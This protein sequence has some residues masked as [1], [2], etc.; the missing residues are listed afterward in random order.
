MKSKPSKQNEFDP[1]EGFEIKNPAW[2]FWVC[3]LATLGGLIAFFVILCLKI[4][5]RV[6]ADTFYIGCVVLA[7][8]IFPAVGV[9]ACIYEKFIYKNGVYKYY[10]A[11]RKPR[12]ASVEKIDSV[13]FLTVF[14]MTK[15]GSR[16]TTWVFFYDKTKNILIK[17][18]DDGTLSKNEQFLRSLKHNRIKLIREGKYD[19]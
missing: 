8:S 7:L 9:Y 6:T 2:A 10:G 1:K 11:F 12:I 5:N 16:N 14:S 15:Y 19:Y 3:L 4:Q 13:K 17:T 18:M